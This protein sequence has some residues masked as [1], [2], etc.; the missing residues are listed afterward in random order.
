MASTPYPI[1]AD[2]Q[3]LGSKAGTGNSAVAV[4]AFIGGN[5]SG[6]AFVNTDWNAT[7]RGRVGY[8]FGPALLY[9]TGALRWLK[10][11]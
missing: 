2:W 7:F 3:Y 6:S 4:P 5:F 8:A 10:P 9:A 11:S 1:E